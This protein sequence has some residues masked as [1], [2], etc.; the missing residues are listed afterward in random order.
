M[1]IY[2]DVTDQDMK[3]EQLVQETED[4]ESSVIIG[5]VSDL[6]V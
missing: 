1:D 5:T 4:I 6:F 3:F 2:N